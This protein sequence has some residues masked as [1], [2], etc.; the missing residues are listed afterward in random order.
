VNTT[1]SE[2]GQARNWN[3]T[4]LWLELQNRTSGDA[5]IVCAALAISM[6]QI[7]KILAVGGTAPL[8]F[9][10]HDAGHSFRVAE[11]MSQ[12]IPE[13]LMAQLSVYE[14]ALLLLSAYLHDIG[15]TPERRS[16]E[17]V[18][19]FLLTGDHDK[20]WAA[21][22]KELERWL[23]ENHPDT[24]HPLSFRTNPQES[25]LLANELVTDYS[26]YRHNDWSEHWIR[27]NLSNSPLSTY[28]GWV[29]DLVDLCRSH[30][31]SY[32]DLLSGKFNPRYV[33]APPL[34]VHL[35]YL[36]AVLRVADVLELDPERTPTV[37]LRHRDI[38]PESLIYWWKDA[39]ISIKQEVGKLSVYARP[40]NA[41][42]HRAVEITVDQV[43][44]ELLTCRKLADLTH[45][46][47][48]PASATKLPHRW[49][50]PSAVSDDIRPRDNSYEYIDGSFRPDTRKL[51]QLLSGVELYG[52]EI[53]AVRELLQ[54]AFDA[55]RE[56]IAYEW[57]AMGNAPA[58]SLGEHLAK[59]NR[60]ELRLEFSADGTWLLCKDTGVGMT[61]PIIRDHL[62]VSGVGARHDVL[63]LERKCNREGFSLGRTGQFGIGVL[64]YFMMAD[65]VVIR[66]KRSPLPGDSEAEGWQFETEGVGSFGE[67]RRDMSIT[68]GTE[69]RL[70]LKPRKNGIDPAAQYQELLDYVKSITLRIPCQLS[71]SSNV[72]GCQ[73]LHLP[74]GFTRSRDDLSKI[75]FE[76]INPS[77]SGGK[78]TPIELLSTKKRLE[79]EAGEKYWVQIRAECNRHL[80]FEREEGEIPGGLGHYRI[81]LPYFRFPEGVSLAFL[82][83]VRENREI[84]LRKIGKGYCF[85][86]DPLLITGWKGMDL[87]ER[88][89]HRSQ[90]V[91]PSCVTEVDWNSSEAG[92]ISVSRNTLEQTQKAEDSLKWLRQRCTELQSTFLKKNTNSLFN[93]LNRRLADV[94]ITE[95]AELNWI[96]FH[97][98]HQGSRATWGGVRAPFLNA[99][100]FPYTSTNHL[101]L[102][103]NSKQV[104]I[105]ASLSQP[106]DDYP[107]SGLAWCGTNS[108]PEMIVVRTAGPRVYPSFGLS[109]FW[110]TR[111]SHSPSTH[112]AGLTCPYPPEW[113]HICGASFEMY[114]G[115]DEGAIVWN[116]ANRIVNSVNTGAWEWCI[117][118]FKNSLDPLPQ[119][120]SL[121][122]DKGKISSWILLCLKQAQRELWEG[123]K[124]RDST[125]LRDVWNILFAAQKDAR[126]GN[127]VFQWVED[128]SDSRLRI[129]TPESWAVERLNQSKLIQDFL[130]I[131][132]SE[133]CVLVTNERMPKYARLVR[134]H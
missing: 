37:I 86:V 112:V 114:S 92:T 89:F 75:I 41:R 55:V 130:P 10:L 23:D 117:E 27:K 81:H 103:W 109:P 133:W 54:N 88:Y 50:L 79:R 56:E 68:K 6:P 47:N 28:G 113:D 78:D 40:K 126:T 1:T 110:A 69:V 38:R 80:E 4:A 98:D 121:L 43:N 72:Q 45:F 58:K 13:D 104:L 134:K 33:G 26:R 85:A 15:M 35:R 17:A 66:T 77:Y 131:P 16:V 101:T 5:G 9:T 84:T 3:Q 120:A 48:C 32:V 46:E 107:H 93:T 123:L 119:K 51:L 125:F 34:M 91:S 14:L 36:A 106:N 30:H 64:S 122:A 132:S 2:Q 61:K 129:L 29:D 31:E 99:I 53:V 127:A 83:P 108:P 21:E 115:D 65:Q 63:E 97:H 39:E 71:L 11:R 100:S 59:L 8:D 118:K 90:E 94:D 67:L 82:R 57:L 70:R 20:S 96:T 74:P 19:K 116:R 87:T 124:D 105:V 60:V 49:E 95:N 52:H 102:K 7:E 18:Y 25:L 44:T 128:A 12:I 76:R 73:A 62:L 42:I 22:Q 24:P 111:P